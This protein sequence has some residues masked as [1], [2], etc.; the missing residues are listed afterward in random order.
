V[1]D[2]TFHFNVSDK[3]VYTCRLL[4]KAVGSG[5]KLIVTGADDTLQQLDQLLWTFSATE[6]VS[7]CCEQAGSSVLR[8]SPVLLAE[9]LQSV[10]FHDV[11]VNLGK[12]VPNS[13]KRFARVVEVVGKDDDDRHFARQRWKLYSTSGFKLIRHDLDQRASP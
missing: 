5:A 4:R 6:F 11:L 12:P 8:R 1:T 10:P 2:I 7:H 3:L 9:S 13:F